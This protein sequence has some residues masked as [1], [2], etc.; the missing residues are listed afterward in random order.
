MGLKVFDLGCSKNLNLR[1]MKTVWVVMRTKWDKISQG[2]HRLHTTLTKLRALCL[3]FSWKLHH[4]LSE[5]RAQKVRNRGMSRCWHF[6]IKMLSYNI[7]GIPMCKSVRFVWTA[8][9]LWAKNTQRSW[10]ICSLTIC[11]PSWHPS[12]MIVHV[13]LLPYLRVVLNCQPY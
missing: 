13:C 2:L 5:G 1:L 12:T 6:I 8:L 9:S 10:S 4:A 3:T 7:V 11:M